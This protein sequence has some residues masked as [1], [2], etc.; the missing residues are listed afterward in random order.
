MKKKILLGVL[1][2]SSSLF[3]SEDINVALKVSTLGNGLD[4]SKSISE[5]FSLRFNINGLNY[6]DTQTDSDTEFEGTLNLLTA[7]VL[8]DYYPFT[9]NFRLSTGLY[10]NGNN[11]TG[12][13]KPTAGTTID[14]DGT[15]YSITDIGS[16]DSKITFNTISPYLGLGWGND[17][18]DKGWGFTFDLGVL[19]H[20][21][22]KSDLTAN[23]INPAIA[24]QIESD[25]VK[26]EASIND[27]LGKVKLYPVVSLGVN[28][29]F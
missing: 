10:Y 19:Y 18:R 17:A 23:V 13:A 14:I 1:Y 25:I 27:D 24:A 7:G 12:T 22:G 9:T 4:I 20:G 16:L 29:T 3:A 28:Y 6:S 5:D 11:F 15:T 2:L 21:Q 8:V 26:E